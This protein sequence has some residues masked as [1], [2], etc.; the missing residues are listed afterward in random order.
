MTVG[1]EDKGN[2]RRS[3]RIITMLVFFVC[4]VLAGFFLWN[5][6]AAAPGFWGEPSP[7]AL[8]ESALYTLMGTVSL[9]VGFLAI[10][11]SSQKRGWI[12]IA[13]AFL[14]LGLAIAVSVLTRGER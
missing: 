3:V 10:W 4:V 7:E 14:L 6:V 2:R 13:V 12:L 8:R 1:M 11:F 5:G 9:A